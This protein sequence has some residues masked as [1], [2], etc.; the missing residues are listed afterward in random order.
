MGR[1]RRAGIDFEALARESLT[2]K[3]GGATEVLLRDLTPTALR[4]PER[5]VNELS[6]IFG[7]GVNGILEPI[8]R[9]VDMGLYHP[10]YDT[11][12]LELLRQL[13]PSQAVVADQ[14]QIVLHDQRIQDEQGNYA[15]DAN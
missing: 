4:E 15:D 3:F 5:F 8:V 6:E 7:Q 12:L 9:Y 14:N 10:K 11:P 1:L 13:G 2:G